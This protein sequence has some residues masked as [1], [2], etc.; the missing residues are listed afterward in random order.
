M[1]DL[2][3]EFLTESSESL[4]TVDNQLV[5]FEQDPNNA[6]ILDNI[7]RLVH[8]IK[9]TCGFLGLPRLEAL[10]HAGETLMGK[11]RDGMP[12]TAEAV[13][14]ILSS[15][16][17]IKEILG[18]LEATEAEPEGNDR[19]LIDQLEAMVEHGMAAMSD[20]TQ[21]ISS[22]STQSM[23]VAAEED[24]PVVEAPSVQANMTE[25]TLVVQT[26]ERPLRPGEVSLDELER[27][28]RE[29]ETEA[30][31]PAPAVK[32]APAAAAEPAE[33]A[34]KPARKAAG[35]EVQEGDKI[36]NQSIRVNVDTL[37][38]LMTMVSELVLTRNQLL[39]ISRRNEDT[40]F[41]VPLQRLSNVTA[42]L[43]EGVMKTRMQPIGNAWQKLPRIVRDL[44]GELGKQI[45][46]EMHGADTELDRQVLDLIKDPL[47]HM[48]RN[49]A[50]HGLETTA[51]R[52]AAGKPEQGTI[53]LS[54]YHE[55][56][57]IIICIADNGRGLNTE[58]I[59][60][61]ALQNGLVTEAELEK[62]TEAQIHKFIFAPGFSTAAQVTS[63]SGRGV[64]MDVVRTNIDQIGG[65][66]DI[67]SV[68]GEGASVT[69]KIPLTL[70]IVSALIV[71]AG[72][73]RFA[74]PQLSVV[75]L[76][77][78]RANSEHRIERIKDTAVLRLR[79]KL[80]PLIHLKKLLKIDDGATTTDAENGFIVVTQVGS[81]TFGIV[82]DGVFHT[83]EIVVKPMSTKL[84]HIDMFSGN[85]ILGDGAVIMIIDPNGIAKALGASGSSAHDL[86]DDNANAHSASGEQLTSLLVFR[87]GSSQPKAVP[88]GLVTRLEEIATDKI[89]LSNGRYMVQYREQL[90]PLVQM[91]GVEVQSQ[92]SQPILVFADDGRSMGLVV[93]EIIDI[94]EERLNI[95]VAGSQD[96]IL[97]SA[98]IKGQATEVIDVGHFLPMA[99]ADWFSRKEMRPSTSAQS[100]LL[101]DDS[102]F[103]RNMLAPVLKAAGY[104]VRT[105]GG[106][107][108]GLAAL[109]SGQSFDVV[110]TDIEMPEMNGFEFAENIR[111]DHNLIGLPIIALSAMVSPAA[112]ERGRQAG[113]HDYVAKFDRPGLIAALK[114][115]TAELRRAA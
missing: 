19:D 23:P 101:V 5:Q 81:Q 109:R 64:G 14:L 76:V 63:V 13:T 42:E 49:S 112:I 26:L 21:S 12:V 79:N 37:E 80:L 94:V 72:G 70:A 35:E 85:T 60:A 9:G 113:F 31:A 78:A 38:H 77:R 93:D 71:E 59:K 105:A 66:I 99:F 69:I 61:K 32:P 46:L 90:M 51:E 111:S 103:F 58:R 8:T 16:D 20:S 62:M 110:L 54:A 24:V 67:K 91:A 98:V 3:R 43:Q 115:Q 52:V 74:I 50:D 36:A 82:V 22:G 41:K 2:L 102:A 30:A 95:E 44:S 48:V 55:G 40:E 86:A 56:G 84:R 104:K 88:L 11:F 27:A 89:E 1:D 108:E 17:R 25:G 29:T 73:D 6:K 96:G 4:D 7:F 15:I 68:A 53:R 39:E 83:E 106:A 18:G 10:A 114:E 47:T 28:F 97:G 75:E 92:G 65:T 87:A 107:Q 57:H 34:K 45:E 100:V 33:A